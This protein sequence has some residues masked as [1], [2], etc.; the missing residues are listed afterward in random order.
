MTWL[1]LQVP[2]MMEASAGA[3][4]ARTDGAGDDV[5]QARHHRRS[6]T[7]A[8]GGGDIGRDMAGDLGGF[9]HVRQQVH[10]IVE[11]VGGQQLTLVASAGH[12][13]KPAA[14]HIRGLGRARAGEAVDDKILAQENRA[15]SGKKRRVMTLEP[16]Q[17]SRRLR[18]PGPLQAVDIG[19]VA[20][21]CGG[22]FAHDVDAARVERL[23]AEQ[24]VAAA[25]QRV[26]PVA[27]TGAADH[28]DVAR[29]DA[30][31]VEALADDLDGVAPQFAEV[32]LDMAGFWHAGAAVSSGE[33]EF[34]TGGVEDDGL[35]DGVARIKTQNVLLH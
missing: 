13:Q 18:R 32:P 4:D 20:N 23:D 3:G 30:R 7:K 16:R 34:A 27:V 17:Q 6:R 22:P 35:D 2:A 25:V 15:H 19:P 26:E 14:R 12:V 1:M 5:E 29:V 33:R 10:A 24:R 21:A 8:G 31:L 9:Q 11:T 28:G